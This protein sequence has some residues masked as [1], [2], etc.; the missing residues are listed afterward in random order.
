[1]SEDELLSALTS[2]NPAKKRKKPLKRPKAK[3]EFF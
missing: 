1:M 3:N 2:S